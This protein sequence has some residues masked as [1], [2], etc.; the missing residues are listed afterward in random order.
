MGYGLED[1]RIGVRLPAGTTHVYTDY[2]ACVR[3]IGHRWGLISGEDAPRSEADHCFSSGAE[4]K[5][6]EQY[7]STSP[8]VFIACI[9]F[10][11]RADS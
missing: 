7:T 3:L 9:F 1:R 5:N 4:V 10:I 8:Y 11:N 2:E 6:V